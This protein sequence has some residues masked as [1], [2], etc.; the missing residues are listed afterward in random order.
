M[1]DVADAR[2]IAGLREEFLQSHLSLREGLEAE[3]LAAVIEQIE[4]EVDEVAGLAFRQRR[5]KRGEVGRAVLIESAYLTIDYAVWKR[6]RRPGDLGVLGRPVETFSGFQRRLAVDHPHLN[7]ISIELDLVDPTVPAGRPLQLL[8]ELRRDE[9]R[10]INRR[11]GA[12]A[13]SAF[14]LR[15]PLLCGQSVVAVPDG[16]RLHLAAL[17][18]EGLRFTPLA[19]C[20]LFHAAS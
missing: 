1:L 3:I 20:D 7:A 11:C 6:G 9:A 13:L 12:G 8:A 19:G 15:L 18:H 14:R 4:G 16:I 17:H 5:L 2:V 10:K